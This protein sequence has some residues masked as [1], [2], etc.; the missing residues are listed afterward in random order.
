MLKD[1]KRIWEDDPDTDLDIIK[2]KSKANNEE[3]YKI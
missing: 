1:I 2:L 3:N